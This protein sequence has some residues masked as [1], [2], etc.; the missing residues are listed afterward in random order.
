[1]ITGPVTDVAV[2]STAASTTLWPTGTELPGMDKTTGSVTAGSTAATPTLWPTGTDPLGIDMITGP[3]T[4]V[5]VGSTDAT[6]CVES[7]CFFFL[8][9]LATSGTLFNVRRAFFR[10]SAMD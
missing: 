7:C 1:M 4:D 5:A 8:L 2:G 9:R 6:A 3:V 10:Q